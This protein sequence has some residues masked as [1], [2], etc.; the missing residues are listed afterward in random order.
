VAP[1]RALRFRLRLR[2]GLYVGRFVG[3][4]SSVPHGAR[5]RH[6]RI[7]GVD[8]PPFRVSSSIKD[9]PV[10]NR[11][12]KTPWVRRFQDD[13]TAGGHRGGQRWVLAHVEERAAEIDAWLFG[14]G[15]FE[16]GRVQQPHDVIHVTN[17]ADGTVYGREFSFG[18]SAD[19]ACEPFL[20]V[21]EHAPN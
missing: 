9:K 5:A 21:K 13:L 17:A 2:V 4:G 10:V 12:L 3:R 8:M 6:H 18:G 11:V 16:P 7:L 15:P 1:P 20:M 14:F 19:V